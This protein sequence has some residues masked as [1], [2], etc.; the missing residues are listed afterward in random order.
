M[1]VA[2]GPAAQ[3][4]LTDYARDFKC[5][6][7]FRVPD[8]VEIQIAGKFANLKLTT[9]RMH[10]NLQFLTAMEGIPRRPLRPGQ[11]FL[12]VFKVFLQA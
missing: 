9:R 1:L 11:E 2:V 5:G 4:S 7:C 6:S 10:S 12:Q 8:A 3:E